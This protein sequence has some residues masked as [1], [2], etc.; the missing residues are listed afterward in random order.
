M[1]LY[2]SRF[3]AARSLRPQFQV[4]GD[5]IYVHPSN[6][7]AAR[8]TG[9]PVGTVAQPW[10]KVRGNKIYNTVYN[11]A[12]HSVLPQYEI[13][14]GKVFTT[15]HHPEGRSSRPVFKMR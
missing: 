9:G 10:F 5:S 3:G 4:R 6:Y 11:P 12:G 8:K 14:S 2:A 13:R 1:D 15:V 7:A